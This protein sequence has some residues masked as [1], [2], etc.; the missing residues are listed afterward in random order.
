MAAITKFSCVCRTNVFRT[1]RAR[2]RSTPGSSS[3][4]QCRAR[5]VIRPLSAG[6][7][8][9]TRPRTT[10]THHPASGDPA[11]R[12]QAP[13]S[14]PRCTMDACPATRTEPWTASPPR[15]APGSRVPSPR[16]P[17][18]RP[19]RGRPSTR[20]RTCWSS[21]PPVPAR[22]WPPSW[23]PWTSSPR[24]LP[25]PIPRSAA[26]S[27]TSRPS[28]PWRWTSSATSAAP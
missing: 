15:P 3:Y 22:P 18:P 21:P 4:C 7:V 10:P 28:R 24:P 8:E 26:G 19:A 20:A 12:P 2:S 13:L 17:P 23:P 1:Y 25:L 9:P 14:V 16:P 6:R 11:Q 27:C 5:S